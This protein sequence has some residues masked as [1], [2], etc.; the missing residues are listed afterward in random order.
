MLKKECTAEEKEAKGRLRTAPKELA[1]IQIFVQ[2]CGTGG[3]GYR[4]KKVVEGSVID[5]GSAEERRGK[6]V[7]PGLIV[8]IIHPSLLPWGQGETGFRRASSLE[9]VG[10]ENWGLTSWIV[11]GGGERLHL[12]IA[13]Y[14]LS[15]PGGKLFR[16]NNETS[17]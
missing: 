5:K 16:D 10:K 11:R 12:E 1:P 4:R 9:N 15:I 17:S 3:E 13:E 14:T 2:G 8:P 6:K 7:G